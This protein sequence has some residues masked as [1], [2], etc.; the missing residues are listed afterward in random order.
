MIAAAQ[1]FT[2]TGLPAVERQIPD[3]SGRPHLYEIEPMGYDDSFNL[4][5]ELADLVG[6]PVGEGIKAMLMG[7]DL[8]LDLSNPNMEDIGRAVAELFTIPRRVLAAGG[9]QLAAKILRGATRIGHNAQGQQVKQDLS[10]PTMRTAAYA[11]GNQAESFLAMR[12]VIEVNYGPFLG[13]VS[14]LVSPYL[15]GF[16]QTFAAMRGLGMPTKTSGA[17]ANEPSTNDATE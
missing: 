9:A 14:N 2:P 12:A 17:S 4:G 6:G 10:L 15:S 7:A 16:G 13:R 11:G 8:D 1:T 5:L 3:H